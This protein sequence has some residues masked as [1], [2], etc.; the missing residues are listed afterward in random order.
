MTVLAFNYSLP[1]IDGLA[2]DW[3]TNKL[4][5]TDASTKSIS[6]YDLDHAYRLRLI[7]LNSSSTPRA[8]IVDPGTRS[9]DN[10]HALM[11]CNVYGF[12][13][14]VEAMREEMGS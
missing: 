5:W 12:K 3:V 11:I 7:S 8:I 1:L 6:V 2:C 10:S 13:S 4:Y 14:G 9:L